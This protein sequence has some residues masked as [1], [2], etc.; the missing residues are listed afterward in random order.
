MS[1]VMIA[2]AQAAFP[3]AAELPAPGA[4]SNDVVG[5]DRHSS[6]RISAGSGAARSGGGVKFNPS[7][8]HQRLRS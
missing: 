6:G 2:T 3:L 7:T 4:A 1:W 5:D 8:A